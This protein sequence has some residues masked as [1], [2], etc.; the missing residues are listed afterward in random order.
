MGHRVETVHPIPGLARDSQDPCIHHRFPNDQ[1]GIDR[2]I[3]PFQ[4]FWQG[5]SSMSDL[6]SRLRGLMG[7]STGL[8]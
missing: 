2:G 6:C 3:F 5:R 7:V 8:I 4:V 1:R